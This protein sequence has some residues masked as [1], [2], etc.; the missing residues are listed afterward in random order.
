M[1][2]LERPTSLITAIKVNAV[3]I[4]IAAVITIITALANGMPT[5]GNAETSAASNPSFF[6]LA[7]IIS[8]VIQYLMLY[9]LWLGKNWLRILVLIL[10]MISL[11][12]NILFVFP[13][14]AE[15][16]QSAFNLF[17]GIIS[18]VVAAY[19]LIVLY[20]PQVARWFRETKTDED[21]DLE[22]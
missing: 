5:A 14:L 19:L 1:K 10:F 9:G 7:V 6:I 16:S 15:R 8:L 17:I 22:R 21:D 13:L 2:K 11:I 3:W 4:L 12:Y 18:W 20:S